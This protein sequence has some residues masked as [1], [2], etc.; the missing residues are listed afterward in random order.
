MTLF[1]E[2]IGVGYDYHDVQ[3]N[4]FP[5]FEDKAY[6]S[7][8]WRK[9]FAKLHGNQVRIRFVEDQNNYW[10]I[11]YAITLEDYIGLVKKVPISENYYRFKEAFMDRAILRFGV[12]KK[13]DYQSDKNKGRNY[14]F[15]VLKKSKLVR[16]V[17]FM[18]YSELP[19]DGVETRFIDSRGAL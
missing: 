8:L 16:D 2:F 3:M 4:V 13:N 17:R 15:E 6:A 19:K 7:E 18:R 11:V 1:T 12:Y 9:T 5:L 10:F 14:Q